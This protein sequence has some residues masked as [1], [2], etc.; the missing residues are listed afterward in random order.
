MT[1]IVVGG[2]PMGVEWAWAFAELTCKALRSNF[3]HIDP[4]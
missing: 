1:M 3:R 2:G 4:R